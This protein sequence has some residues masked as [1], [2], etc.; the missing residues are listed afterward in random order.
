MRRR[1][2]FGG[3]AP[4]LRGIEN[5]LRHLGGGQPGETA[6]V[7]DPAEG[8]APVAVKPVSAQVGD[9]ELFAAHG[10][11]RVP[12][13]RLYFTNL[14]RHVR[15]RRVVTVQHEYATAGLAPSALGPRRVQRHGR[16]NESLQ[17]RLVNLL[18]LV[19]VDGAPGV[20]LEAGVE[21]A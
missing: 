14:D 17:C 6:A 7:A 9:L 4:S 19:K 5:Q 13:E 10:L 11:H 18:A 8:Q 12:E 1:V 16:A 15:C 21:E 2:S 20:P 3:G